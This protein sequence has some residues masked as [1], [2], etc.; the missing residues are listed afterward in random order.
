MLLCVTLRNNQTQRPH[1]SILTIVCVGCDHNVDA[2]GY[3]DASSHRHGQFD[4]EAFLGLVQGIVDD[5]HAAEGHVFALVESDEV[6]WVVLHAADVVH[7]GEH[8]RWVGS[9]GSV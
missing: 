5:G 9:D 1:G 8:G 4:L 3:S 7:V 6:L 2:G